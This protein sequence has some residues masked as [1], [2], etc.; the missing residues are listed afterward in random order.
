MGAVIV[1]TFTTPHFEFVAVGESKTAAVNALVDGWAKH[2][3][4]YRGADPSYMRDAIEDGE[5]RFAT[6]T[7]GGCA[8]DGEPL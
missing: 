6:L 7:M 4:E 3:R 1:A 8:R 2:R 5:V